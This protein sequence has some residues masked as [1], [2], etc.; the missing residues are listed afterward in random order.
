VLQKENIKLKVNGKMGPHLE[1]KEE[2]AEKGGV[3]VL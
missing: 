1:E 3:A 2:V